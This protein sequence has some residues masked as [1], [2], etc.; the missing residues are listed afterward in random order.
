VLD[1]PR[2]RSARLLAGLLTAGA[3]ASACGGGAEA[4]P[5][6][7]DSPSATA[8]A[9]TPPPAPKPKPKP[10]EVNPLTGVAPKPKGA[11]VAVK[12]DNSPLAR[13]Y[14]RGLGEAALVYQELMEGGATRFLAVYSPAIGGE[15]G[16][17]RSVREGDLEL[18]TQ[19]GKVPLAAS[20]ANAGTLAAVA[21]AEKAGVLLDANYETVPG[22]YRKAERRRD[23]YNFYAAP[24]AID[25]ARP[26]GTWVK[27][28]GL[29]FG[30][31]PPE[32][33]FPA[34]TAAVRFSK[35]SDVR[36]QYDPATGRYAVFNEGDRLRGAAPANVVVQHVQIRSTQYVDVL[37][38][39]TPY[40]V[41]VGEGP[42][43]LLRDGRR[44]SGTWLRPNQPSGT[45]LLDD[46]KRDLLLKPG[47]TWF[48][49]VPSGAPL[50]VR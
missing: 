32:A 25:H 9:T 7:A 43:V 19:F 18:L 3:L 50:D 13:P 28:I 30:P 33:G 1:S 23:A 6:A 49:L 4:T 46:K 34:T 41:T 24:A 14:H 48:L 26:G 42:A 22:P 39:R 45:R 47:P 44:F 37:G 20:G 17:I 36:V 21:Q 2:L 16:P 12:I 38:N 15:V 31:V 5:R 35:M 29:R 11:V 8:T 27:D 10:A 40:T